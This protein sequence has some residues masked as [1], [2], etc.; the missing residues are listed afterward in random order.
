MI[1][2]RNFLVHESHFDP[3]LAVNMTCQAGHWNIVNLLSKSRGLQS[4]TVVAFSKILQNDFHPK[5]SNL[6]FLYAL[7]EPTLTQSLLILP[8]NSQVSRMFNLII[9]FADESSIFLM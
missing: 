4:E 8:H 2:Y 7:S 5:L 6:D 1:V 3:I 9:M